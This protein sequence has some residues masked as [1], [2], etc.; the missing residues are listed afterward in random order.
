MGS[1]TM[2]RPDSMVTRALAVVVPDD[3]KQRDYLQEL[4]RRS[5]TLVEHPERHPALY[6]DVHR[7]R[8]PKRSVCE[9]YAKIMAVEC[10]HSDL[11]DRR[12]GSPR[13]DGSCY[14]ISL[15]RLSR[16]T[17]I[18]RP[19]ER[20]GSNGRDF[21]GRRRL[22]RRLRRLHE[23]KYLEGR[24]Q[25][26]LF[27]G[28]AGNPRWQIEEFDRHG[29]RNRLAGQWISMPTV[30][31]VGVAFVESV[32]LD[33][34]AELEKKDAKAWRAGRIDHF[35]DVRRRRARDR[36]I[37]SRQRCKAREERIYYVDQERA[38]AA[39][40]SRRQE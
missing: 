26:H 19:D 10:E 35:V 8:W 33:V 28:K 17:G 24:K 12:V 21:P 32:A 4:R 3:D 30:R 20:T 25:L 14:G 37:K 2:L 22:L 34:R 11:V 5:N 29:R 6:G 39:K 16:K 1:V 23:A 13:L 40:Q 38:L 15:R 31:K 9:D 27:E 7:E 18:G 36:E